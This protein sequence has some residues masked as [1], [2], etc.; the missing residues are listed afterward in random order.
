MP[1]VNLKKSVPPPSPPLG[2]KHKQPYANKE[3]QG[4]Y[5]YIKFNFTQL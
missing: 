4:K 2:L 5:A 3:K 1:F